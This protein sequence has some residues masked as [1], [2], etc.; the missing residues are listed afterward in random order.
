MA[1][2][3]KPDTCGCVIV[4]A[5]WE[6]NTMESVEVK[7]KFHKD[8][9]DNQIMQKVRLDENVVKNNVVNAV[10]EALNVTAEQDRDQS[11][12]EFSFDE[13]RKLIVD[14]KGMTAQQK[15]LVLS[16]LPAKEVALLKEL[17]AK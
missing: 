15:A 14:V 17:K 9:P 2:R 6:A 10:R 3:W 16:K 1:T 7:C 12:T 8:I 4:V 5:D 11:L 13:D